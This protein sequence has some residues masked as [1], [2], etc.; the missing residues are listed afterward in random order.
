MVG[1]LRHRNF[2]LFLSGQLISITGTWMQTVAQSWLVYRLTGSAALLGTVGFASQI[3]IFVFGPLGGAVADR[4]NRHRVLLLTQ[5]ASMV[6]AFV[7]AALTLADAVQVWHIV[8][9]ALLLGLVNAFDVASRQSFIADM[10]SRDDLMNAIA[11]NSSVFNV[12]RTAGPAVAGVLVG[13]VGEGWC[14]LLNGASY[15]A[16]LAG[17]LLMR[18]DPRRAPPAEGSAVD[19]IREGFVYAWRTRPIR[20]LLAMLGMQSLLGM[21]YSVLM[22]IFADRILHGGPSSLGLLMGASGL[23]ALAG[24]LVLAARTGIAGLARAIAMAAAG[25]GALLVVFA[26]SESFMVSLIVMLPTGFFMIVAMAASNTLIQ[27]MVAEEFRGRVMSVYSMM[28][29]GMAPLGALAAGTLAGL[30]GAPATVAAG[31]VASVLGAAVFAWRLPSLSAQAS[32]LLQA[33]AGGQAAPQ[34]W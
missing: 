31:G 28:F 27:S 30:I 24:A 15:L 1:A 26:L 19:R 21:P 14:F 13:L 33:R 10:V 4:Y 20:A 2:R 9:L 3:G 17:L 34:S 7:L 32:A 16:V 8:V 12:A 25:F 18:V 6:L 23:G 29:M 11:L 22:P 5:G